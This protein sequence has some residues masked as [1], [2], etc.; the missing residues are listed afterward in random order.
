M[1]PALASNR[2]SALRVRW[3]RWRLR[4]RWQALVATRQ[5]PLRLH[6]GCGDIDAPGFINV[7]AR[8]Q[9][10]VHLVTDDLFDLGMI[11][12]DTVDLVYMCHVLEHVA[13]DAVVPTLR[14]MHRILRPGGVL[15]LSVPDFDLL[16]DAYTASGRHLGA[17]ERALMGGQNHAFNFHYAVFNAERLR[18]SLL[19]SG[20]SSTRPWDPSSCE[21]HDFE[22]WASRPAHWRGGEFPISLNLEGL[23]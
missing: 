18:G 1:N 21:H 10:H 11:P 22:D 13:L 15:R 7:D 23:K 20:F 19:E 9:P 2:T 6:V 12:D 3:R 4:R 5:A 8:P 16:V 14:E 17:V